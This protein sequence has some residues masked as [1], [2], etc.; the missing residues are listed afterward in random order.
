MSQKKTSFELFPNEIIYNVFEFLSISDICRA[1]TQLNYRYRNVVRSF[2]KHIDLTD[3]WDVYQSQLQHIYKT[4]ESIK[5]DRYGLYLLA[6]YQYPRLQSLILINILEW[7]HLVRHMNL[8]NLE[9][10]FQSEN[11]N[12][13]NN[14]SVKT[15]C[16]L[17][18]GSLPLTLKR[19]SSNNSVNRIYFHANLIHLN[20][21]VYGM[22]DLLEI[23]GRTPNVQHLSVT[24][25]ENVHIWQRSTIDDRNHFQIIVGN[26]QRL[27]H[28]NSINFSTM[29]DQFSFDQL[30]LFIDRCC[31]NETIL[32]KVTL[33]SLYIFFN[34]TI[35]SKI[36]QYKNTFD[37]FNIYISFVIDDNFQEIKKTFLSSNQ[38]AFHLE[39]DHIDMWTQRWWLH[40][41]SLPFVFTKLHGFSSYSQLNQHCSYSTV[42]HLYFT[43]FQEKSMISF[44]SLEKQMPRLITVDCGPGPSH[45]YHRDQSIIPKYDDI[46]YKVRNL[47]FKSSC[48]NSY[49]TYCNQFNSTIDRMPNL[50]VLTTSYRM[51][52]EMNHPLMSLKTLY[53]HNCLCLDIDK[54]TILIPNVSILVL[55]RIQSS[56]G[57]LVSWIHFLFT[58]LAHL[59]ALSLQISSGRTDQ[60]WVSKE[61]GKKILIMIQNMDT[62]F[63]H[64]KVAVE[65]EKMIFSFR[66]F[67][68]CFM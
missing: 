60:K 5:V 58:R 10:W 15:P 13:N 1:F 36:Q 61:L 48:I 38:F 67:D 8:Q 63:R 64:L 9:V 23:L 26:F 20:V 43:K 31:P 53:L 44:E 47:Y 62:N 54:L 12:D 22:I 59:I 7:D 29:Y 30:L 46:L 49:C 56:T 17:N 28:L 65:N 39:N 32:K 34:E 3:N 25:Y 45:K 16:L 2:V 35:W 14:N 40:L 66:Y 55:T 6:S 41:Y 68:N 51:L 50:N 52:V 33:Q 42:R 57:E 21:R 11:D 18:F 19:F 24:F 27:T 37:L 4:V